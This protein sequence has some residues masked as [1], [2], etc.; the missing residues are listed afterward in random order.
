MVRMVF[1][2]SFTKTVN[3]DEIE[4]DISNKDIIFF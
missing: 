2:F 3:V 4:I 1:Y